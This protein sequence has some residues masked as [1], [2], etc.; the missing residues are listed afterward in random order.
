VRWSSPSSR[1]AVLRTA[2]AQAGSL[3]LRSAMAAPSVPDLRLRAYPTKGCY[4]LYLDQ[5]CR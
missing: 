2:A 1:S 5:Y 4:Y 3:A